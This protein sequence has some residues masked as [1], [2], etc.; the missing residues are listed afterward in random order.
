[1][2]ASALRVVFAEAA[3]AAAA[4]KTFLIIYWPARLS[5]N[6]LLLLFPLSLFR[7]SISGAIYFTK[8]VIVVKESN[9]TAAQKPHQ[10]TPTILA[11]LKHNEKVSLGLLVSVKDCKIICVN[12]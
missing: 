2:A 10:Q 5:N 3:R 6:R 9:Y 8:D 4:R 11:L 1:V 12:I 7:E